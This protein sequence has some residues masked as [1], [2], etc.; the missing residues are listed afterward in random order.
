MPGRSAS[1]PRKIATL[2]SCS[3]DVE[4]LLAPR[5]AGREHD[6]GEAEQDGGHQEPAQPGVAAGRAG[7]V[8]RGLGVDAGRRRRHR[9]GRP[10]PARAGS[11]RC[12]RSG[13]RGTGRRRRRPR[14]PR[15][16]IRRGR[17]AAAP[18]SRGWRSSDGASSATSATMQVTLSVLPASRLARTS[19]TAA[20]SGVPVP[21][22]SSIRS[23]VSVPQAPSLQTKTRSPTSAGNSKRSGSS[24][25]MPSRALRMRL[26]CGWVRDCSSV[27]RPSSMSDCTKVWS[28][29]SWRSS[30]RR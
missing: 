25:R 28:W 14:R 16:G 7:C 18:T 27:M 21:R 20:K 6:P 10:R 24:W 22:M 23:S 5:P 30:P 3:D 13:G 29:V 12:R 17:S 1:M 19:S 4:L 8:A 15:C 26:R 11:R 9:P 2:P